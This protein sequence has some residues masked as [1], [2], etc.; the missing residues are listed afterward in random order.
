MKNENTDR[1][2]N[3]QGG[4]VHGQKMDEVMNVQMDGMMNG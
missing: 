4:T 2:M 1:M 3:G